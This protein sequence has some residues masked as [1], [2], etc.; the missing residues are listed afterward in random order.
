MQPSRCS[1]LTSTRSLKR[2]KHRLS[3]RKKQQPQRFMCVRVTDYMQDLPI[4]FSTDPPHCTRMVRVIPGQIDHSQ[5]QTDTR[6]TKEIR[7]HTKSSP[8]HLCCRRLT[9]RTH[10]PGQRITQQ[11][12]APAQHSLPFSSVAV[13]SISLRA[14]TTAATKL[15]HQ[16]GCTH[17]HSLSSG[18][19]DRYDSMSFEERITTASPAA[20]RASI[21][22]Y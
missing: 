20:S 7:T 13:H 14:Q 10:P 11:L 5:K 4:I 19:I 8:I 9:K 12:L 22:A 2:K 15:W 16:E 17:D 3:V 6:L 1:I 18:H 21:C